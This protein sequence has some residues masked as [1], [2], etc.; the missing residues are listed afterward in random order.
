VLNLV[1]THS[2]RLAAMATNRPL[3]EDLAKGPAHLHRLA[4]TRRSRLSNG[5]AT[6]PATETSF[7]E[8][9]A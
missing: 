4:W 1:M 3:G 8:Q 6:H 5:Q 2:P 7:R 9:H